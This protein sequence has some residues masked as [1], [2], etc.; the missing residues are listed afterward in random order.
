MVCMVNHCPNCPDSADLSNNL[1]QQ[2]LYK[3][4]DNEDDGGQDDYDNER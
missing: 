1:L 4:N 2:L 3:D